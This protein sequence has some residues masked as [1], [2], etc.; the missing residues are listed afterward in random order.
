MRE[1]FI[2][3]LLELTGLNHYG[4]VKGKNIYFLYDENGDKH[5]KFELVPRTLIFT[6]KLADENHDSIV[7]YI[8]DKTNNKDL[9]VMTDTK[10][11]L[12]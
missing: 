4:Q 12:I 11:T 8:K 5:I 1:F 9:S 2:E 10:T 6:G 3:F 7:K